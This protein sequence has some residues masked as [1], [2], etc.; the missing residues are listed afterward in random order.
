MAENQ[1]NGGKDS[2]CGLKARPAPI[3]QKSS[4][5]TVEV[6]GRTHIVSYV[7]PSFCMLLGKTR[8]ELLGLPFAEIVP[9]G[10]KCLPILDRVY[11]TGEAAVAA[12]EEGSGSTPASLLYAMWPRLDANELPVGV[13]IQLPRSANFNQSATEI[14][15]ALIISGL[16]QHELTE[17]AEE[18]RKESQRQAAELE[19]LVEERTQKL[20]ETVGE[21]EAFSYSVAHDMRSPLRTMRGFSQMLLEQ[22]AGALDAKAIDY[23]ERIARSSSRLD[24]LIQD[25]LDYTKILRGQVAEEPLDL[26]RLLRDII[27]T[28]PDWQ[29]P[30]AEIQ[31]EGTLPRV[32]G[33]EAFLTQC[34]SNLLSNAVKFVSPGT[35]PSV[36]ISA[37]LGV[38]RMRLCIQDNGI[39]IAAERKGKI[40]GMFEKLHP[41][42]EYE[43]TG[44]GLAIARKAAE[45][46][47][48]EIGFDSEF[49]KGS[50][51]WIELKKA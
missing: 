35:V 19:R 40:F 13:I 8:K 47:G 20:R 38:E 46:M 2:A 41:P 26:D 22:Y 9:G 6:L 37:E 5:P 44:I 11:E 42:T 32:L 15:E 28:C 16:H 17:I 3:F 45:R 7:N 30:H 18:L 27:D 50:K 36:Q 25:V 29:R 24:L 14:S 10:D 51:F 31:I 4:V 43:G 49:G 48:A 34:L 39:G 33:N 12:R 1:I 23:L 21:L